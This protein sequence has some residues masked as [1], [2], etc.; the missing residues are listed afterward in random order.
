VH[1]ISLADEFTHAGIEVLVVTRSPKSHA[2]AER[3]VADDRTR[4]FSVLRC[5][6]MQYFDIALSVVSTMGDIYKPDCIL[7][8]QTAFAPAFAGRIPFVSRSAGNDLLRPWVGPENVRPRQ[9]VKVSQEAVEARYVTN[10]NW[11]VQASATCNKVICNSKWTAAEIGKLGIMR[12]V[13]I[14]GGVDLDRFKPRSSASMIKCDIG[15]PNDSFVAFTAGRHVRKKGLDVA[16]RAIAGCDSHL[17]LV[18]G[19]I[20]PETE[21][22]LKL[23]AGLGVLNRIHFVGMIE[24]SKMPEYL[25]SCDICIFP[26]IDAF[27]ERLLAIDYESMGR[28][29]CEAAAAGRPIV[30]SRTAGIPEVV[31]DRQTGILVEPNNPVALR[32]AINH[33]WKSPRLVMELGANARKWATSMLGFD[34]VGQKTMA[35]LTEAVLEGPICPSTI[36]PS[37]DDVLTSGPMN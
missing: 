34:T 10:K 35:I 36:A 26:S 8:S 37:S 25:A 18:I 27:D 20:G 6:R 23:A 19:G 11:V 31:C 17:H 3:A 15:I 2:E 5:L 7:S 30:A 22:L 9:L 24:H 1:G 14:V 28:F 33:L 32:F 21:S 4:A 12:S 13:V 16:I 29:A